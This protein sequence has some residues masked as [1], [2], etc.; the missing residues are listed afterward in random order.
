MFFG[1]KHFNRIVVETDTESA[2][3]QTVEDVKVTLREFA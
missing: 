1:I 2:V 3:A